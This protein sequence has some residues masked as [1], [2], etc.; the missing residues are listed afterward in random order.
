M[1]KLL[2]MILI[3]VVVV[4]LVG[5]S[6]EPV[7]DPPTINGQDYFNATVTQVNDKYILAEV[8]KNKSG[9]IAIGTEVSVSRSNISSEEYPELVVGDDIR[10]VYAGEILEKD[11]P[12]FQQIIS[13]F[14][15]KEDDVVLENTDEERVTVP[16]GED[17]GFPNW[18]LTLSVKNVTESGLTLVCT[19]SG[20]ELTGELQTGSDYKLIV[21]KEAWEDIPTIIEDYGWNMLAYMVAKNDVT[22]F[23]VNWEWLYGKLPSGTYRII[24]G[25]T[26]F[27]ESGDYDN[28]A[29]WTEFE[30]K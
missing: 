25:F 28:F 2:S 16:A 23:E 9:A 26:D 27:R 19:Q 4:G 10:V 30:I 20:G 11:P 13:V 14:K 24:K 29:Y 6:K 1:K 5:C 15:L 17:E 22:E 18:G 7:G 8:T 21:L 3:L 12:G